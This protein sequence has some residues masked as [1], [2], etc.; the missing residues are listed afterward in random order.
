MEVSAVTNA[1]HLSLVANNSWTGSATIALVNSTPYGVVSALATGVITVSNL[2]SGY[3][4]TETK[5][6]GNTSYAISQVNTAASMPKSVA[7]VTISGLFDNYVEMTKFVGTP[8][9]SNTAIIPDEAVR[10]DSIISYSEP[11]GRF[12]SWA[13]ADT[14]NTMYITNMQHIFNADTTIINESNTVTFTLSNKYLG[15]LV[16]DSGEIV[17]LE[18]VDAISRAANKSETI[19]IILEF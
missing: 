12:H 6:Y 17:Y 15:D 14:S 2:N 18:N 1:T 7:G 4:T 19:K 3:V 5:L 10:V 16:R 11:S 8:T 9:S 13:N